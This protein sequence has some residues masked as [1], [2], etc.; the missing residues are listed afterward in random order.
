MVLILYR[1]DGTWVRN[2]YVG[3]CTYTQIHRHT[4]KLKLL[5]L[6][7]IH[8][9]CSY[10]GDA[11]EE[12]QEDNAGVDHVGNPEWEEEK[13]RLIYTATTRD[14]TMDRTQYAS[15]CWT[16]ERP[17]AVCGMG[18]CSCIRLY[19]LGCVVVVRKR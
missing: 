16:L 7:R 5:M 17:K 2:D 4:H 1:I 13:V 8:G 11:L 3:R 12:W 19:I 10:L 15:Q 9:M 14:F 6:Y 18:V